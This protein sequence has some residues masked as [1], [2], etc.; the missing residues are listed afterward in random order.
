MQILPRSLRISGIL[1]AS[2]AL[3]SA[4]Q[5]ASLNIIICNSKILPVAFFMRVLIQV[6]LAFEVLLVRYCQPNVHVLCPC[7]GMTDSQSDL[8]I[9]SRAL[10]NCLC[11]K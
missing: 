10:H 3:I 4:V 6:S 5:R 1:S 9:H 2:R 11:R 8:V 7:H